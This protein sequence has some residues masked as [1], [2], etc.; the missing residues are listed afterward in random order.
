EG[1]LRGVTTVGYSDEAIRA[2]QMPVA[3]F[4]AV[5]RAIRTRQILVVPDA[6]TLPE[7]FA[8]VFSGEVVVVPLSLGERVLAALVG[9]VEAGVVPRSG[10]W[11]ARAQEVAARAALVVALERVA[12]A[13]QDE[14]RLRQSTREI[15]NAILTGAPLEE[16]AGMIT[17]RVALRLREERVA[18]YIRGE[19]GSYLP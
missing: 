3:Q 19:T 15:A 11:Q 7:R 10:S 8:Q 2:L 18:L 12:S 16:I 4:P 1:L 9:K 17:E 5:E 13:Y 6:S 14:M